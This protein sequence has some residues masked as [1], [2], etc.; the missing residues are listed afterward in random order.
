MALDP[1]IAEAWAALRAAWLRS[2][3]RRV[4]RAAGPR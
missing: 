1:Q 2:A 4:L 3:L